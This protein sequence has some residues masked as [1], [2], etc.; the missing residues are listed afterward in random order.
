M[1][2]SAE[3]ATAESTLARALA[4]EAALLVG[5]GGAGLV[6]GLHA[7]APGGVVVVQRGQVVDI[8]GSPLRLAAMAGCVV[9]EIGLA[10]RCA[11]GELAEGLAGAAAG[12]VVVAAGPPGLLDLPRFLWGCHERGLSVLV[13]TREP[14]PWIPRLDAGADLLSVDL[15]PLLGE[16]GGLLAGRAEL[17]ARAR[18]E[19]DALPALLDPSPTLGARLLARLG[20]TG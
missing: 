17:V 19:R 7:V 18:T 6:A 10:D 9:R 8:G 4:A 16:P 11:E 15:A 5:S 3:L 12:L 13:H 2:S 14:P 1:P 20:P